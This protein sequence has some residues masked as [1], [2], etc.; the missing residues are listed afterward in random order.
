MILWCEVCKTWWRFI[1]S[2]SDR[3]SGEGKLIDDGPFRSCNADR[4][5]PGILDGY[6]ISV[7]GEI[8]DVGEEDILRLLGLCNAQIL[9]IAAVLKLSP[10]NSERVI[11]IN[12]GL[13]YDST[14]RSP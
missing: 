10:Q 9:P 2:A 3:D 11:V 8:K 7:A 4:S 12:D 14:M 5:E 1:R 6:R 13:R